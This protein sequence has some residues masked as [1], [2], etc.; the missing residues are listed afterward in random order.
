L[1]V[2]GVVQYAPTQTIYHFN[3]HKVILILNGRNYSFNFYLIKFKFNKQKASLVH[4][5]GVYACQLAERLHSVGDTARNR[6]LQLLSQMTH[7]V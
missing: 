4:H 3:I 1:T 5:Y 6:T 2:G 7:N